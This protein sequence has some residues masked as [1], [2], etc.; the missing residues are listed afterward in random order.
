MVLHGPLNVSEPAGTP[1]YL[2]IWT[3]STNPDG[4]VKCQVERLGAI[5]SLKGRRSIGASKVLICSASALL[6]YNVCQPRK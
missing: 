2:V 4:T 6:C 3:A 1:S 5:R